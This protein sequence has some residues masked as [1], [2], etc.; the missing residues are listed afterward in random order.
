MKHN[1]KLNLSGKYYVKQAIEKSIKDVQRLHA[2]FLLMRGRDLAIKKTGMSG[3]PLK[4]SVVG[5]EF[6]H[7]DLV[8]KIISLKY[9]FDCIYQ[10]TL[11]NDLDKTIAKKIRN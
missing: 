5:I 9:D 7:S 4:R 3:S 6:M 1:G 10:L 8:K 2:I 11:P